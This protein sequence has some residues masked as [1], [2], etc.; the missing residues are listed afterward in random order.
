MAKHNPLATI[1]TPAPK[2]APEM[3]DLQPWQRA[4]F[5]IGEVLLGKLGGAELTDAERMHLNQFNADLDA[6]IHLL[7]EMNR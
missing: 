5:R 2:A 7:E 1:L 6:A 4:R 3:R